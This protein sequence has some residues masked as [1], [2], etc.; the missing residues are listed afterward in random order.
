LDKRIDSGSN[1]P[2]GN[3]RSKSRVRKLMPFLRRLVRETPLGAVGLVITLALLIVGT[4]ASYIAPY[5]MN[6]T[7]MSER[8]K[9]PSAQHL[10]GTDNLG[11]DILS[12]VIY[13]ARV[14]MIV[15]LAAPVIATVVSLVI[16]FL[17]G[18][19]SGTFDLIVQRFV[20]TV[21][22]IPDLIF[23][24]VLISIIG[25]S[26]LAIIISLGVLWGII[27]SRII[28]SAVIG[29]RENAYLDAGRAIGCSHSRMIFRHII[30][31]IMAPTIILF[32]I[33]VPG[34]IL[35]ESSLSFLGFGI[36]PPTPSWG[37]M[38]SG[39]GRSYMFLQPGMVL[40]P[41]LALSVVVYGVNMF[42]DA[43]RD[44]LDPRLKGGVG[45]FDVTAKT[46]HDRSAPREAAG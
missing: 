20:D 26:M 6:E 31:N 15:G 3:V 42:G 22:C 24:M 8:L 38:L 40:W 11:R 27:G 18:Y 17:S 14:S 44:L 28:R 33:R 9:G 4:F 21:Q 32:T 23:L 13:G 10:L 16:G 2:Q 46:D 34:V 12:R 25:P 35:A 19:L 7:M 41:G 1:T 37:G 39:E 29:I 30:P 45:R 43:L 36:P 5:G